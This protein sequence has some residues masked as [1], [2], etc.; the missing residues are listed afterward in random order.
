MTHL[1]FSL[2]LALFGSDPARLVSWARTGAADRVALS[3]ALSEA[4]LMHLA[5][6]ALVEALLLGQSDSAKVG[7]AL[8]LYPL[9]LRGQPSPPRALL[10]LA[11]FR[12]AALS[13][14]QRSVRAFLAGQA[15][16]SASRPEEAITQLNEVTPGAPAYAAARYLLGV[17]S[18]TPPLNDFSSAARYF[19]AAIVEA[20]STPMNGMPLVRDALRLS[21][22]NLARVAYEVGNYEVSLYYYQRLP[23]G[24]PERVDAAFEMAWADIMR[25][26]MYRALGA[27]H[28]ARAPGILHPLRP[29]LDLVAGASLLALCQY[30]RAKAELERLDTEFLSKMDT[31][32]AALSR[33][34][35]NPEPGAG[36]AL[37][38]SGSGL[39]PQIRGLVRQTPA[40]RSALGAA[41]ALA[42]EHTR[43][44]AISAAEGIDTAAVEALAQGLEKT[45]AEAIELAIRQTLRAMIS[46]ADRMSAARGE[47]MIDVLEDESKVLTAALQEGKAA[48]AAP[49]PVET[50]ALGED[51]QQ[52]AFD[53]SFWPD[54]AEWYRSTL[55]SLCSS[56]EEHP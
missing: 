7:E 36:A 6:G 33:L 10:A 52:W 26:D 31:V 13:P 41:R 29:E 3:R 16:L 4:N 39:P 1:F 8:D 22:L 53:G 28:A 25:G 27:V 44:K 51:W 19:Q 38:E 47:L 24:S 32:K 42:A 37:L 35:L 15:L 55:P 49:R 45:Y 14:A 20:E 54:E 11:H 34:E 9:S 18:V 17:A 40:V 50:P 12:D 48:A 5:T 30:G 43:L 21:T 56:E 23:Q 2:V 46:D